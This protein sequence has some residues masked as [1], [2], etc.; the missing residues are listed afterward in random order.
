[1]PAIV[2]PCDCQHEGQNK[3]HG[4]QMRVWNQIKTA[5]GA[6]NKYRCTVCLKEKEF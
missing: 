4:K 5:Q 3:L 2:K 6:K 1:M